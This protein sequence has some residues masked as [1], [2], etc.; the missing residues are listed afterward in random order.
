[1]S[2]YWKSE[3]ISP[4]RLVWSAE[5][6][7]SDICGVMMDPVEFIPLYLKRTL[8][9]LEMEESLPP[10]GTYVVEFKVC[11]KFAH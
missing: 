9:R 7:L 5:E 8:M 11:S 3:I 2:S 4:F 10:S 1:M 6:D